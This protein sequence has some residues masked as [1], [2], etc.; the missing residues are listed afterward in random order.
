MTLVA[1]ADFLTL[2]EPNTIQQAQRLFHGRGHAY[3]GF[4]HITIDW[5]P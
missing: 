4:E 1:L 5:L 3:K 2:P